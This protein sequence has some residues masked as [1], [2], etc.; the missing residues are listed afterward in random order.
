MRRAALI[1]VLALCCSSPAAAGT[2]AHPGAPVLAG[3]KSFARLQA[4]PRTLVELDHTRAAEAVPLLRRAGG[5]L[6]L[7]HI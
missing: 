7:I 5:A 4:Y 1:G 3:S 2:L 6:S